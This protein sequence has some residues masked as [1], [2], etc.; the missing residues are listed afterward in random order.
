MTVLGDITVEISPL[1]KA[2]LVSSA[3]AIIRDI[4]FFPSFEDIDGN[5]LNTISIS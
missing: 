4:I 1:T 5:L 2:F 3:T